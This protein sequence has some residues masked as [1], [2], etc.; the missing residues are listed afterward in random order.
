MKLTLKELQDIETEIVA[1]VSDICCRNHI[2]YF[3]HCGSA[4]GALRH[5]GPIP[6]DSDVD[7][8]IPYNQFGKF[9]NVARREL[10]KKFYVDYYDTNEDYPTFFPRIG[11]KGYNT[12]TLHVDIFKLT[13]IA[14]DRNK[15]VRF[16]RTTRL[17]L[18]IFRMK[19]NLKAYYGNCVSTKMK[20]GSFI[21]KPLLF[22]IP[23]SFLINQFERLCNKYPFEDAEFVTNPSGGYG[24]KNVQKKSIYGRGATLHYCGLAINVPEHYGDYL[25]HYYGDYMQLPNIDKRK[26]Q[27]LYELKEL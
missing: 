22:L 20:W 11:L 24:I 8:I 15:Q 9:L 3:L 6:W 13:G 26:I 7:I 12:F 18:Q 10:P 1:A 21:F 2:D 25:K 4:L 5:G 27:N 17:L 19:T 14:A 16:A 23:R